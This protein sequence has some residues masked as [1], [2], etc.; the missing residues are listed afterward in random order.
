MNAI[1]YLFTILMLLSGEDE[2]DDMPIGHI[3]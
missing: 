2:Y 1:D 3:L